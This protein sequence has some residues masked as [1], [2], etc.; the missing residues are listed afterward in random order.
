MQLS[1]L[2]YLILALK[3]WFEVQHQ[4]QLSCPRHHASMERWWVDTWLEQNIQL[5]F[6]QIS[7][8]KSTA[9]TLWYIP[10]TSSCTNWGWIYQKIPSKISNPTLKFFVEVFNH[11]DH[12]LMQFGHVS[13]RGQQ[14]RTG[15]S[16]RPWQKY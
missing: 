7:L 11:F 10:C 8:Q 13:C 15:F 1:P 9:P 12:M 5:I 4:T 6:R 14:G 2:K 16:N 3:T